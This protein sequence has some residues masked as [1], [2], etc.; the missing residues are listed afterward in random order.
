MVEVSV[1]DPPPLLRLRRRAPPGQEG[2]F[3]DAHPTQKNGAVAYPAVD[4]RS[5]ADKI[6]DRGVHYDSSPEHARSIGSDD[7]GNHPGAGSIL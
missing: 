5:N 3:P 1:I 6:F 4:S 7:V 2:Q